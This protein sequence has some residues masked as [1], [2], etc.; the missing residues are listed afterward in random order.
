[1]AER[2]L[3][4][5]THTGLQA[6]SWNKGALKEIAR[7]ASDDD[8]IKAFSAHLTRHPQA[9]CTLVADLPD[10]AFHLETLPFLRGRDRSQLIARRQ[11]QLHLDTPYVA[12]TS[13]GREA[14][15]SRNERLL[16]A[17][18]TRPATLRPWLAE[19]G[20]AETVLTGVHS[21]ALLGTALLRQAR[22][23]PP[24]ALL[25]HASPAGLRIS[26]FE[27]GLLRF[28]RLVPGLGP[29]TTGLWQTCRDEVQ[30]TAQ[31]LLG[32][33]AL[34]RGTA[35]PVL[36]LAHPDQHAAI[37]MACPDS[38]DLSFTPLNLPELA[39]RCGL[40]TP[41]DNSDCLSLLLHLAARTPRQPQ[42]APGGELLQ[43]RLTRVGTAIGIAAASLLSASLVVATK[44]LIDTRQLHDQAAAA[45]TER[46]AETRRNAI[47]AATTPPLP[48]PRPLLQASLAQLAALQGFSAGPSGLFTRLSTI[49]DS[50]PDIELQQL[51]WTA[52]P[53]DSPVQRVNLEA[54]LPTT[55]AP[56]TRTILTRRFID[57]LH[58]LPDSTLDIEQQPTAADDRHPLRPTDPA[59]PTDLPRLGIRI[60]LQPY[61]P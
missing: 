39:A 17:A 25:V 6:W 28:S 20:R 10:E 23:A 61:H 26:C 2:H 3:L 55:S 14:G 58:T 5:L 49:L 50:H 9:R 46:V 12:Q 56:D 19:L 53:A 4:Y 44:N 38:P 27:H 34:D 29:S 16:F 42:F 21:V 22:P 36:V 41:P 48:I 8:G 35:T 33:R 54:S 24:R 37:H 32:Q 30:R 43:Q 52:T 59:A 18:L 15:G 31:Y 13:L 45:H 11:A 1:M 51:D 40:Q 47:L 57:A 7:F 60:T